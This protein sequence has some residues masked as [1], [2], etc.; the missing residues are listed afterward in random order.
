MA[1]RTS[2]KTT[3]RAKAA[4]SGQR[5]ASRAASASARAAQKARPTPDAGLD[6]GPETT[7]PG[8]ED[9]LVLKKKE[10][11]DRV[12]MRSGVKKKDAK[13]V[14]E[15]MMQ[16]LGEALTEGR[17][18]NLQPLGRIKVNKV[19]ETANGKVLMTRIRQSG[20]ALEELQ[21][22]AGTEE[23]ILSNS[24]LAEDGEEG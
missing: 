13:P 20:A 7:A 16:V 8:A 15:A 14:I 1:S 5:A 11:I 10:L 21:E 2:S 3:G 6:A 24:P 23:E 4:T 22:A 18:L 12:V 17:D 19:K 9:T